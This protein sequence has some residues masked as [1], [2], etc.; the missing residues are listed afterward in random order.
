[1][2][3]GAVRKMG[4]GVNILGTKEWGLKFFQT[5]KEGW[6]FFNTSLANIF[7]VTKKAVYMKNNWILVRKILWAQG[8]VDICLHAWV[9]VGFLLDG[10]KGVI[11]IKRQ[12]PNIYVHADVFSTRLMKH[13]NW[14][15]KPQKV[16]LKLVNE[17]QFCYFKLQKYKVRG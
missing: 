13:W 8:G 11:S 6:F 5:L 12:L 9:R 1:M 10:W 3:S 17:T 14:P 16:L 4:V 15:I 7:N 2:S